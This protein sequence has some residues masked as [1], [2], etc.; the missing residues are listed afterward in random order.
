MIS[1]K[2]RINNDELHPN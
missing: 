1:L 2:R